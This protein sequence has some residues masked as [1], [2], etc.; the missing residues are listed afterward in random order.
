[1]E[2]NYNFILTVQQVLI[3]HV[4]VL[5]IT[6]NNF[7]CLTDKNYDTIKVKGGENMEKDIANYV[8]RHTLLV[9]AVVTIAFLVLAAGEYYLY[10]KIMTVNRQVSE[11]TM[12]IQDAIRD[13][14]SV[15]KR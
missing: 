1:M 12:Q 11:G 13:L 3:K 2:P 5:Y 14:K 7:F 15:P 4:F 9:T 8:R 10:R 6:R